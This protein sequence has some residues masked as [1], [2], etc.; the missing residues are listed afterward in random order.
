MVTAVWAMAVLP[1]VVAAVR[2]IAQHWRPIG[3]NALL[4]IRVVDVGTKHHPWLGSWTSASLSV[5]E[6]MNNPGPIYQDLAAPFAKVFSPGPGA[7][8]QATERA[9]LLSTCSRSSSARSSSAS[10]PSRSRKRARRHS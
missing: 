1:I 6:N 4:Y 7:A 10:A 2:A 9:A 3:D 8:P 5:G